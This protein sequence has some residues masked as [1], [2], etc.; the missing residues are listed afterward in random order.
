MDGLVLAF[1]SSRETE[2]VHCVDLTVRCS[3]SQH[4]APPPGRREALEELDGWRGYF[5]PFGGGAKGPGATRD[6]GAVAPSGAGGA[7]SH[8]DDEGQ[9]LPKVVGLACCRT[10]ARQVHLACLAE[11]NVVVWEDPHLHLSCRRPISSPSHPAEAVT[12]G[13]PHGLSDGKGC[14]VDVQPGVV[15]VG[16]DVSADR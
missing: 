10:S 8:A 7:S 5:S 13:L 16:M 11:A 9:G 4:P 1:A 12:Y 3:P 2:L 14:A 6:P 15:A